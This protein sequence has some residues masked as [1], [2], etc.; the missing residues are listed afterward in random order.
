MGTSAQDLAATIARE[1]LRGKKMATCVKN[2]PR[3][4]VSLGL[5]GTATGAPKAENHRPE[6]HRV[7]GRFVL[8]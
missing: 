6:G 4:G 2:F 7:L 1:K 8:M 5:P 3:E